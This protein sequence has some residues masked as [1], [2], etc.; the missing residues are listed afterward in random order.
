MRSGQSTQSGMFLQIF[1]SAGA[2]GVTR[3]TVNQS[4][5]LTHFIFTPFGFDL[6]SLTC[7]HHISLT[8]YKKHLLLTS[9]T[10]YFNFFTFYFIKYTYIRI[11]F[12]IRLEESEEKNFS[13]M[14][15]YDT[16][17]QLV[18][19]GQIKEADKLKNDFKI[20]DKR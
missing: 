2:P 15:L 8:F 17:L 3:I 12:Q 18:K 13:N 20:A 10:L 6:V 4:T 1:R 5:H 9:F 7:N 14:S 19:D 16:F 11:C